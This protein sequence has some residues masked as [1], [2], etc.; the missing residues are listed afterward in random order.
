MA[1]PAARAAQP[2][3]RL[4]RAPDGLSRAKATPAIAIWQQ[5]AGREPSFGRRYHRFGRPFFDPGIR[6]NGSAL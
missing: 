3:R 2:L 6:E 1:R 5:R 4:S